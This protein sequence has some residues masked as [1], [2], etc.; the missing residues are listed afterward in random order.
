M[1]SSRCPS[2]VLPVLLV[3]F[4]LVC[5]QEEAFLMV[6]FMIKY[7]ILLGVQIMVVEVLGVVY[8]FYEDVGGGLFYRVF[9]DGELG[10]ACNLG[11]ELNRPAQRIPFPISLKALPQTSSSTLLKG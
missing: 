6:V 2:P 10:A 11:M 1:I 7:Y 3:K 9:L 8:T 4:R 5:S